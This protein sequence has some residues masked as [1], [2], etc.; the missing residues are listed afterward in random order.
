MRTLLPQAEQSPMSAANARELGP[1]STE[2]WVPSEPSIPHRSPHGHRF[3]QV[4]STVKH[5]EL[6]R[7]L[8]QGAMGTVYLARDTT[9]GRLVAIKVLRLH[10]GPSTERFLIEAQAT[11]R[12]RHDNIVVIHEVDELHGYPYMV[13]EYLDGRTL[14]EWIAQR[15]PSSGLVSPSLA[16]EFMLPVV[17]ALACAHQLGIVHRDLK[18]ENIFLTGTGRVVVLDFGIAKRLDASDISAIDIAAPPLE[19]GAR[20]TQ[21][22]ALVGTL[23]YMSPEQLRA[24]D[25]DARSDLWAVGIILY[26]LVVGAH[27]SSHRSRF[28]FLEIGISEEPMPS[29]RDKRPDVGE[30]GAIID[31][32]LHK[33]RDQRYRSAEE[34]LAALEALLPGRKVTE[35]G[36]DESPFTGLSAFQEADAER[37][38]GREREVVGLIER[39]RNQPLLVV[40]GPSGAGKSSFVRAG[41]IPALKR[42]GER[43]K[44]VI[45]RPGRRPLVQLANVLAQLALPAPVT[46][47]DESHPGTFLGPLSTQPGLVG[48]R[49]RA[50]C[51]REETTN[52]VLIF[53]DQFE[54]LYTLGANAT[55]R[56]TFVAALEGV[57]D[58]ASSPLRVILSI[59]SDFL[60]R[61][62]DEGHFLAEVTRGLFFLRAMSRDGLREA[63]TRPL[64]ATGYRFETDDMVEAML[65]RIEHTKSPLPLLQFMA[66]RLWE[67]RERRGRLLTRESYDKSGGVTGAL[68]AHAN[69]VYWALPLAD[70]R[71]CRAVLLRLCTPER[72]RAV[73]NLADLRAISAANDAV[74]QVIYRL[75]DARLV[76]IE[77]GGERD[78]ATVELCHESLID[79]WDKLQQWL[80]ESEHDAQ[81]VARVYAAA[82]QW[83]TSQEAEGLLWRDRAARE[84]AEWLSHRRAE[85]GA[86]EPLGIGEREER[87]LLAV[88]ALSE[89]TRR[90]RQRLMA[91]ALATVSVVATVVFI[92]SI[93]VKRQAEAAQIEARQAAMQHA[94]RRRAS[95][96]KKTPRRCSRCS[97]RSNRLACRGA[98]PSSPATRSR[99]SSRKRCGTGRSPS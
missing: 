2:S 86:G 17:R 60:Y 53:V 85:Q 30:L 6:L 62:A 16:I 38:V 91:G 88:V 24:E 84:A 69:A 96:S 34:L 67:A 1:L 71:L 15:D 98:G 8:G 43:W 89:R 79:S 75:S 27:P 46:I 50:H 54:E 39:L 10:T 80:S 59:R 45:L 36:E 61:M 72:T 82:Q 31:Q 42:S 22:G 68:S 55:E 14:R 63:L 83:E 32:C 70:Q 35:L 66:A 29:V 51:R 97:A 4:G 9:L 18:P 73:V 65:D 78:G 28:E 26:E 95:W 25:I 7:Q 94:W 92:L 13:L 57:A 64:E 76:L 58:D 48:A 11:A 19:Q 99:A 5:Y 33:P 56:A 40:T 3:P 77:A 20:L 49:L 21:E 41:V 74:E 23:P 44:T 47:A 90:Q 81:F 37:Y 52:H 12:C 93:S 87:F